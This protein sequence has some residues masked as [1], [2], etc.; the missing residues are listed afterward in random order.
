MARTCREDGPSI[1]LLIVGLLFLAVGIGVGVYGIGAGLVQWQAM[2]G[3]RPAEAEVMSTKLQR[4]RDSDGGVTY[5][6]TCRYRYHYQ[7]KSYIGNRVGI[8][9]SSDNVGRWHQDWHSRL[10]AA[11]RRGTPI[12]LW[13]DPEDPTRAILDRELRWGKL[14]FQLIFVIIFGGAG[15]TVIWFA[16]RRAPTK[17]PA[18]ADQPWLANPA[19]RNGQVRSS[20]HT[21]LWTSWGVA[22][23]WNVMSSPLVFLVPQ[24]VNDGNRLALIGLLFP[25][26]GVGIIVFAI[27]K[28]LEWRRFGPTA[29]HLVP[30]PGVVG[31]N[32]GGNLELRLP[33]RASHKFPVS[34][35][36]SHLR[37][38]RSSGKT[39]SSETAVWQDE[40][41]AKVEPGIRGTRVSFNFRVPPDQPGSEERSENYHKWALHIRSEL[42]GIDLDRKFT[43]P[44]YKTGQSADH[45]PA[46]S[47]P[48]PDLATTLP[49]GVVQVSH[50]SS[51]TRFHYPLFRQLGAAVG[52]LLVGAMFCG[53][54]SL[55]IHQ[56]LGDEG[57]GAV[58]ALMAIVFGATSAVIVLG[59][60][61][62]LGNSLTVDIGRRSVVITRRVFGLPFRRYVDQHDIRAVG[63]AMGLQ[64][65]KGSTT[66]AYYTVKLLLSD[67]R[68]V[69][70]GDSLKGASVAEAVKQ[71]ISDAVGLRPDASVSA[72]AETR[73]ALKDL[74]PEEKAKHVMHTIRIVAIGLAI[75]FTAAFL[76]EFLGFFN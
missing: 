74:P 8:S 15:A 52:M 75:L 19:W 17:I 33:Y 46:T 67:G 30:F 37:T 35:T 24:E 13:V 58:L 60:L 25:V 3:W 55:M 56:L 4:H 50:V 41:Q 72:A 61:Y 44:V 5:E 1:A 14:G 20:A 53:G 54:V 57:I 28:A 38:Y 62:M 65:S 2:Q 66:I 49:E 11:L 22:L 68:K 73:P 6:V 31:G 42:P 48:Q 9:E 39:R 40:A 21:V 34:L 71:R 64:T 23:F 76:Y 36:C 26:V 51:G 69:T 45:V 27:R 12:T 59:G 32:V 29:L 7:G 18:P 16:L 70:V 63:I 43:V 10:Q 47:A